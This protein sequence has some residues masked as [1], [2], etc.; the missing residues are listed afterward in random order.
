MRQDYASNKLERLDCS[1]SK[2]LRN[3]GK[4]VEPTEV[5]HHKTLAKRILRALGP[6]AGLE[7]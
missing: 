1:C 5:G 3:D 2:L 6:K 7:G 4:F